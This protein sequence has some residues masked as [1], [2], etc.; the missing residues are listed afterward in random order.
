MVMK[1]LIADDEILERI[2]LV[3]ILNKYYKNEIIC[4]ESAMN[5][6]DAI[7]KTKSLDPDIIFMDIKMPRMNGI[8]ASF[9]IREFN[10][11]V[12][13]IIVTAFSDFSFA[14]QAITCKVSDYLVKPYSIKTLK[15]TMNKV[16]TEVV[17]F[18]KNQ[19]EKIKLRQ[20]IAHE[21]FNKL[22]AR[23][24]INVEDLKKYCNVLNIIDTNYCFFL[25]LNDMI[26]EKYKVDFY[27]KS[28]F[29]YTVYLFIDIDLKTY[30]KIIENNL[31]VSKSKIEQDSSIIETVFVDTLNILALKIEQEQFEDYEKLLYSSIVSCNQTKIKMVG[32]SI[33]RIFMIKY[34]FSNLFFEKIHEFIIKE[35]QLLYKVSISDAELYAE[36]FEENERDLRLNDL[37]YFKKEFPFFLLN[38]CDFYH[39]N[40][41]SSQERLID[42]TIK[43]IKSNYN[44]NIGMDNI[45]ESISVSKSYLSRVFTKYKGITVMDYLLKVRINEAKKKLI[46]GNSI[47]NT[48]SEVGFSNPAYFSKSFKKETGI[49]PSQFIEKNTYHEYL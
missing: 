20:S 30:E 8:E 22:L 11:K 27:S 29:E 19:L 43:Y 4:I 37:I 2:A 48:S 35:I 7:Q 5:G 12:K 10:T 40:C 9:K 28:F 38:I 21:F 1:I 14:K 36:K 18:K 44:K 41:K 47:S 26:I 49:S 32:Q 6:E 3:K 13:I 34:G 42:K 46:E 25:T 24:K 33:F 45:S 39:E 15:N 31:Y 17:V 23:N 16:M